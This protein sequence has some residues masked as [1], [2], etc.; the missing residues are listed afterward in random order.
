MSVPDRARVFT[1][2]LV[3][4]TA[5]DRDQLNWN[6][7][8]WSELGGYL[9]QLEARLRGL[10]TFID[11]NMV[12]AAHGWA[13]RRVALAT[14]ID[15]TW[16][17]LTFTQQTTEGQGLSFNL[18]QGIIQ[19][20]T[21]ASWSFSVAVSFGFAESQQGRV[22]NLRIVDV[23]APG[24]AVIEGPL[25]IARNTDGARFTTTLLLDLQT[26][27]GQAIYMEFQART[28]DAFTGGE[29]LSANVVTHNVSAFTGK[30]ANWTARGGLYGA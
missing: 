4:L 28:G 26:T 21:V 2:S 11:Q 20:D 14:P 5:L 10:E 30:Y 12:Y 22:I 16:R 23:N 3:P 1:P 19:F 29:V 13:A 25:P 15:A 27:P 6:A 7:R 9:A 18:D 24:V 17:R 8:Q